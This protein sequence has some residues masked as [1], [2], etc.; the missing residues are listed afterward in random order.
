MSLLQVCQAYVELRGI[1]SVQQHLKTFFSVLKIHS[2][3]I[4]FHLTPLNNDWW[5]EIWAENRKLQMHSTW[6]VPSS[7]FGV[8]QRWFYS[9]GIN[10]DAVTF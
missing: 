8:C 10:V 3:Y 1:K 4:I 9:F 5:K 6:I 2:D 7:H